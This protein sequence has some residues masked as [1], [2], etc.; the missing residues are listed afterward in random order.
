MNA[1]KITRGALPLFAAL[2][3]GACEITDPLDGVDIHLDIEDVPVA[4]NSPSVAV[5]TG[6]A[7]QANVSFSFPSAVTSVEDISEITLLPSFF[8]YTPAAGGPGATAGGSM[9]SGVVLVGVE[10]TTGIPLLGVRLT[11]TN[12]AITGVSPTN[13]PLAAMAESIRTSAQAV[14][15]LQPALA[16]R[17]QPWLNITVDQLFAQINA[18]LTSPAGGLRFVVTPI[19]G[20]VNGSLSLSQFLLSGKVS[21]GI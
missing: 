3:L 12:D 4:L 19:S 7:T 2:A 8:T 18:L 5:A 17:F 13:S 20:N 14:I 6:T 1:M 11:I 21:K 10:T 9:A 15:A 16:A